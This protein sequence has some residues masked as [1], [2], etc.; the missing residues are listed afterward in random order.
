M[1]GNADM[2]LSMHPLWL[3]G[4]RP[5]FALACFS[6]LALPLLWVLIYRGLLPAPDTSF[7][8]VQWHAHEMFFGFGWAVL[9]GFLL[10]A[11]KNW[12]QVRGYHGVA[13]MYLVAA[14]LFERIGMWSGGGW[15]SWLF[16]LSNNLFLGSI[17]AMLAWT[18]LRYRKQDDYRDNYFFLLIF[19][20][21]LLAKQL[22][23]DPG[24]FQAGVVMAT[25]LFRMAFLVMLE[26][27]LTQ[28]MKNVFQASILRHEML[29]RTIKLLALLLVGAGFLPAA[30][31]GGISLLLALLLTARFIFWKPQ[32]A[33]RRLELGTDLERPL[34]A[35][36][37]HERA[38]QHGAVRL[39]A[40]AREV[41]A[42]HQR[43]TGA[44][45]ADATAVVATL[46]QRVGPARRSTSAFSS[47]DRPTANATSATRN[48]GPSS[49]PRRSSRNAGFRPSNAWPRNWIAQ[50][51][52]SRPAVAPAHAGRGNIPIPVPSAQV[53]PS[54]AAIAAP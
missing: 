1:D 36:L 32:L 21:F 39:L 31:A 34:L 54:T 40:E 9:G 49:S 17:T 10:T 4:F 52:I 11:T 37:V 18:L 41:G 3:V 29:D 8:A 30:L 12:V 28:F 26:R 5:F 51:P 24:H 38:L 27:T 35:Q 47:G 2:N 19:P 44:Q 16:E 7:A 22:L 13:L 33:M 50:P 15:P 48:S 20:A 25:G 42:L 14:W 46:P 23:L 6:G 53:A 43:A 45:A